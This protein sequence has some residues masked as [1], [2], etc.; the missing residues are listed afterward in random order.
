M[1][2]PTRDVCERGAPHHL[3]SVPVLHGCKHLRQCADFRQLLSIERQHKLVV[4][5]FK[6]AM[7]D[8]DWFANESWIGLLCISD[9][10][11]CLVS[12]LPCIFKINP[13]TKM[14]VNMCLVKLD[15]CR[16][17]NFYPRQSWQPGSVRFIFLFLAFFTVRTSIQELLI[18][19]KRMEE[20]ILS[21]NQHPLH[22]KVISS[23]SSDAVL[24]APS[25]L[26]R[27]TN[28][29]GTDRY[30]PVLCRRKNQLPTLRKCVTG[31]SGM[32]KMKW[33]FGS[34][35]FNQYSIRESPQW[36]NL[37]IRRYTL[38]SSSSPTRAVY[39]ILVS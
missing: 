30:P 25:Y 20:A 33:T 36:R 22:Q 14:K 6:V 29:L 26:V 37:Q 17:Y 4:H 13:G 2:W 19:S 1:H 8:R 10:R 5:V 39:V 3:N 12:S 18:F 15:V 16:R 9:F 23:I 7:K 31:S 24:F 28:S 21:S 32:Q 38:P 27:R 34:S 35:Q 11:G